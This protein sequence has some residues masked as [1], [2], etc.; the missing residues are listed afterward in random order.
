M[1]KIAIIGTVGIPARYGG[2][3]TLV[4]NLTKTL[5]E[6]FS[7]TVYCSGKIYKK[8]TRLPAWNNARLVY[9]PLSANGIA[10][11]PY[12]ILSIAHAIWSADI[13]LILGVSGAIAI[14]FVRLFT[15]KIVVI[16]IDGV[17]WKRD[18]WN[19]PAKWFLRFSEK[20]AVRF[21][22]IDVTDNEAIKFYT[23]KSYKTLSALIEYGADHARSFPIT[24]ELTKQYPFLA[25]PYA[26]KVCR[27]EPENNV[28][29]ILEAFS[30][31]PQHNFV[32]VGNWHHSKFSVALREQYHE[33]KNL[34]MLDPI[35][36][37]EILNALRSN[38][39]F[40]VHGHSAGG[41]NP[42]L[43]EAMYLGC[44]IV[45]FDVSYNRATTEDKAIYFSTV[46][47]LMQHVDELTDDKLAAVKR[48]MI[49]IAKYRYTWIAI[50]N[51]YR[52][53]FTLTRRQLKKHSITP[54]LSKLPTHVLQSEGLSQFSNLKSFYE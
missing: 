10:S 47:D 45:S 8:E 21:S 34:F 11:I 41:T 37:A 40:Y 30:K 9:L 27:I 42:S 32:L 25:G 31:L 6:E 18:K 28:A 19:G 35:Y 29:M 12:D 14:P 13:L 23:A 33:C 24:P 46:E 38:C 43:V 4:E 39:T 49:R 20:I 51:K 53:C 36:D 26:F 15:R 3:E 7:F 22:H 2:F 16:N 54:T 52:R 1:K 48:E 17:E 5:G 50:A 44:P